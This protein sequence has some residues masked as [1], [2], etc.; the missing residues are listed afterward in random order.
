MLQLFA[1]VMALHK[2]MEEATPHLL[3]KVDFS[4]HMSPCGKPILL[5]LVSDKDLEVE[6][7]K[8]LADTPFSDSSVLMV[9]HSS[10]IGEEEASLLNSLEGVSEEW[11][12]SEAQEIPLFGLV[13]KFDGVMTDARMLKVAKFLKPMLIH[14]TKFF[15]VLLMSKEGF[16]SLVTQKKVEKK[17]SELLD[18]I[19]ER[20]TAISDED[21]AD[22]KILLNTTFDAC[23]FIAQMDAIGGNRFDKG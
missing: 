4:F 5:T 18:P 1:M 21:M 12:P 15:R 8:F 9:G 2:K 6:V 16:T 11:V 10:P 20:R 14:P 22:L 23:D 3:G 17:S 13:L 19:R 7:A